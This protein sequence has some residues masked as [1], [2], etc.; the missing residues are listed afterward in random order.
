MGWWGNE[1]AGCTHSVLVV[2]V[3]PV[4]VAVLEVLNEG[5]V[6][7][8]LRVFE[9]STSPLRRGC[10]IRS[11]TAPDHSPSC[12]GSAVSVV[13][14][15]VG[16]TCAVGPSGSTG[17]IKRTGLVAMTIKQQALRKNYGLT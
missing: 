14:L 12:W 2:L 6:A 9:L 10:P 5:V 15:A 4:R 17:F 7:G 13:R 3:V 8:V 16:L 1:Y 11:E